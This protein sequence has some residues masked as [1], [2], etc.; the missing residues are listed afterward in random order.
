MHLRIIME[1][2]ISLKVPIFAGRDAQQPVCPMEIT[3]K[4]MRP[5]VC[6]N[7]TVQ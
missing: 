2:K 4:L 6:L 5:P 1:K 3:L 7:V